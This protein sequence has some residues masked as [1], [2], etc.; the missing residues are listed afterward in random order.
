MS[1]DF[2]PAWLA[3]MT[4][5]VPHARVTEAWNA[6]LTYFPDVPAWPQLERKSYPESP[7]AQFS[8]RFPGAV[9]RGDR[10]YIDREQGL[11]A[12]LDRL[13]IAYLN[14][15]TGYGAI[16]PDYAEGLFHLLE[17][18]VPFMQPMQALKGQVTGPISWGLAVVD[19]N[20]RPILYD[21]LLAEALSHLLYL[22]AAWQEQGLRRF[23]ERTIIMLNEPHLSSFGPGVAAISRDQVVTLLEEVLAGITGLKGIHCCG[24]ADWSILL[25]T[26]VDILSLDAYSHAAS[27]ANYAQEVDAFLKRGGILAWGIVPAGDRAAA[28]TV[29]TLLARLEAAMSLLE[30]KGVPKEAMVKRGMITPSCGAGALSVELAEQVFA[31][32]A[33][34][35]SAMRSRY[36]Y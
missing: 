4:G 9:I 1:P 19:Q 28:E 16:G 25:S 6:V 24:D 15:D 31:L 36:G 10:L 20:R 30:E 8:E 33:G 27:L 13:F 2:D 17:N 23:C 29:E 26:S 34:V 21:E 32:T 35:S 14:G 22:K 12:A 11:D 7:Y 3:T 18:Q 5:G